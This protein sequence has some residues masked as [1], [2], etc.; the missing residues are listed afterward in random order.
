MMRAL[1]LLML[2]AACAPSGGPRSAPGYRDAGAP[3]A[4]KADFDAARFAGDWRQIARFPDPATAGCAGVVTRWERSAAGFDIGR[5]CVGPGGGTLRT[6]RGTATLAPFGR[7]AL[8]I[9]GA[10]AA[11]WIL[12]TDADYRTAILARPDGRGAVILDRG[13]NLP[14]DRLRAALEVLDFN[15]FDTGALIFDDD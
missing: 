15:G 7:M 4:S 8:T 12:W 9:D 13:R 10:T 3:V 14:D 11:H 5:T 6:A 2:L 1:A